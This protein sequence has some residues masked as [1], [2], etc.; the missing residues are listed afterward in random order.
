MKSEAGKQRETEGREVGGG[1]MRIKVSGEEKKEQ[2]K[3]DD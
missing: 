1:E 2:Q 3:E